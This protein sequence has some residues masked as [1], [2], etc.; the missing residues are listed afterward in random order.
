MLRSLK[1][2]FIDS[3]WMT[4]KQVIDESGQVRK[5]EHGTTAIF[6]TMLERKNDEEETDDIPMLKAFTVFNDEQIDGLS[7]SDEAVFPEETFELLPR[8][9]VIFCNSGV[10]IIEKG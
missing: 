6:Y 3:R 8:A 5:G 10:T 7:M 1:Q 9:K 2:G 4:Y